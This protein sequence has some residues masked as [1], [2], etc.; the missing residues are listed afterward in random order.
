MK[1]LVACEESQVLTTEFRGQ[2][3]EAYSCDIEPTSGTRP[4]WHIQDNVLNQ[5]DYPWDAVIAF[6]PCTHLARSGGRWFKEKIAD[7]RQQEAIEFFMAFVN[8]PHKRVV[9]ENPIGIM[10]TLYRKP[11]QIVQPWQFGHGE[12]KATCLWLRGLPRLIPT[13]IASKRVNRVYLLPET[14]NR[15][16]LRSKTYPGIARAMAKQWKRTILENRSITMYLKR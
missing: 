6:P 1:V 2:G 12:T 9:I 5:L 10:S 11:D 4:D 16:K 13:C 7:N 3:I 8:L 15:A 14:K